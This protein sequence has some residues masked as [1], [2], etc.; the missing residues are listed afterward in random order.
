MKAGDRNLTLQ[1]HQRRY[2]PALV[3][4]SAVRADYPTP[5]PLQFIHTPNRRITKECPI[6]GT[7]SAALTSHILGPHRPLSRDRS[8][9]CSWPKHGQQGRSRG[10]AS[11]GSMRSAGFCCVVVGL[12]FHSVIKPACAN[13]ASAERFDACAIDFIT[14]GP[15]GG[16]SPARFD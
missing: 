11:R 16:T 5:V 1:A 4:H 8:L 6:P 15:R 10:S 13:S 7:V 14:L 9:R 3:R 2:L 12:G